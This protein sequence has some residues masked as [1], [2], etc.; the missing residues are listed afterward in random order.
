MKRILDTRSGWTQ[1]ETKTI[2]KAIAFATSKHEGQSRNSG[3]PYVE[4]VI[5]A[6]KILA[7]LGMDVTTVVAGILHDTIEDTETT[8]EELENEF[9]Y[10]VAFLVDGVSKLGK[11]KYHGVERHVESLRKFFVAMSKDIRVVVIKLADRLHN[12]RTLAHVRDDKRQRIALETLEIHA[13]LADRLGM[14]KLKAELETLAFPYAFPEGYKKTEEIW[15]DQTKPSEVRILEIEEN[16]KLL[17][18]TEGVE[19]VRIDYRIK[20][21][22]S[23]YQKLKKYNFDLSKIHDVVALRVIVKSLEDCYRT[24][25]L[26]HG[27]YRPMPGRIKDYIAIPKSNGYKSLHT[28]IFTR[29]GNTA[30]I[31]I[32]TEE[33]HKE[34]EY[35]IASHLHYKEIGKNRK[36][37]EIEKKTSWT[38]DLLKVQ[39]EIQDREE[40]LNTIKTDFFENRVFV[41]TPKGDVIDLP[42]G[43]SCIDFA[44][45]IHT[46]IGNHTQSA[47]VNGKLVS[48][49][50]KLK[51]GD[52]VQIVTNKN[53]KPSSKWLPFCKT[54]FA[55]KQIEKF[56]EDKIS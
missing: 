29:D 42:E 55:R 1:E 23:L 38:K 15:E 52:V 30:E 41:F 40:F 34:A 8:F 7:E 31:Q 39:E 13:R 44:Y 36:K 4:H 56:L 27:E 10:D 35:G 20:H 6:G 14:G 11:L 3:E 26:I 47:K 50:N 37:E 19:F 51:R 54:S 46:D 28:T 43:A 25:G 24:L 32:R 12:M 18:E 45:A 21:L 53:Q 17:L 22:Y 16:L 5:A 9:G 33:M 49:E 48:I 2:D